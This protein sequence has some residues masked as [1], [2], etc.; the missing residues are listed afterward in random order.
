MTDES[1]T[2]ARSIEPDFIPAQDFRA[3]VSV[4]ANG[5]DHEESFSVRDE[6]ISSIPIFP[7]ES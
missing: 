6:T 2:R 4:Y 7:S 3:A 1:L 5:V